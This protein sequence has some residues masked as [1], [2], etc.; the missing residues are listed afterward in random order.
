MASESNRVEAAFRIAFGHHRFEIHYDELRRSYAIS[1][2][3]RLQHVSFAEIECCRSDV[4]LLQRAESVVNSIMG[5]YSRRTTPRSRV[6]GEFCVQLQQDPDPEPGY[7]R[8]AFRNAYAEVLEET[9]RT[10]S[11]SNRILVNQI[12][13]LQ[14]AQEQQRA[15]EAARVA[16]KPAAV[17][18]QRP[19]PRI[20]L[21]KVAT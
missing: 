19:K 5:I 15:A 1:W 2:H 7:G 10:L 13:A 21:P 8:Q 4:E 11:D 14:L 20:V 17:P 18:P 16:T 9:N 3:G 12:R 6:K